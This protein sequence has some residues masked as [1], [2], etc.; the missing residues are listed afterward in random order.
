MLKATKYINK[1]RWTHMHDVLPLQMCQS[2]WIRIGKITLHTKYHILENTCEYTHTNIPQA[3]TVSFPQTAHMSPARMPHTPL[4]PSLQNRC[5]QR[6]VCMQMLLLSQSVC[7]TGK[8]GIH[9]YILALQTS[10]L[11]MACTEGTPVMQRDHCMLQAIFCSFLFQ[12]LVLKH[13]TGRWSCPLTLAPSLRQP[14]PY[15]T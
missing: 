2:T 11:R 7:R 12:I 5:L 10:R 6:T 14:R 9:H 8:R 13:L 3:N 15:P 4:R 1:P